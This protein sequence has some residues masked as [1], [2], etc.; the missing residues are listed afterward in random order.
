M[1]KVVDR[2]WN[3]L[4]LEIDDMILVKLQPFRQHY[5]LLR[6]NQKFSLW[7]FKSFPIIK[8]IGEVAYKLLFSFLQKN[9]HVFHCTQ[10]KLCKSDHVKTYVPL[11]I[12]N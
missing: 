12:T 3:P 9:H 10:L 2:R 11:P 1:K 7:Y 5:V 6:K 8:K 4:Q